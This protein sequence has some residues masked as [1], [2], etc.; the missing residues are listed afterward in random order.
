MQLFCPNDAFL[1]LSCCYADGRSTLTEAAVVR[2]RARLHT[3]LH[4][5]VCRG[6]GGS[7]VYSTLNP[8]HW[9]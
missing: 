7:Q 9:S 2:T 5:C 1:V 3:F 8:P 4:F 6:S